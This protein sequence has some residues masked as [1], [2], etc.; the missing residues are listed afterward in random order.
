[1]DNRRPFIQITYNSGTPT[2]PAC[3]TA[4]TAPANAASICAGATTLS[5]PAVTGATG[6]DVYLNT[7][8]T[9]TTVVSANQ[10]GTTY[11][12]TVAAGTYAWK[13]VPKNAAGDA[14]GCATFNFTVNPAVTP[15][16]SIA[17]SPSGTICAGTPVTFTATATNGGAA[18][19]FQ[20]K[21]GT[22]NVGTSSTTYT[23]N[24]LIT[25][26]AI[27]VVMTGNAACASAATV[28]S[29]VITATVSPRPTASVTPSGTASVCTGST[30]TLNANTG[31]GLTYRWQRNSADIAGANTATYTA[32]ISGTYRVLVSNG[33][34]EDT[35]AVTTV[36]ILAK[37][38][39]TV[40]PSGAAAFCQGG[41]VLLSGPAP[42]TGVTYQWQINGGNIAG[43]T[44]NTYAA[45]AQGAYRLVLS[46]GSCGD[47]SS[48]VNI[49]VNPVPV[50]TA[51][52]GGPTTFC[53]GGSVTLTANTG[54]G[55]SYSWLRNTA[56][57][58]GATTNT[59][60]ANTSGVYAVIVANTTTGCSDT[61]D[62]GIPRF[63][64]ADDG[65]LFLQQIRVDA[66]LRD[67]GSA[68]LAGG[69]AAPGCC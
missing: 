16:I 40:S 32:S 63:D 11:N 27:S 23:D 18:P 59:Y 67:N 66:D 35:S 39:A 47:T 65:G 12:A 60:S 51:T 13:V 10:T 4:P 42:A 37:P 56:L 38:V 14:T 57:I 46:N 19:T 2:V 54:T 17:A 24:A 58:A 64:P 34:C 50:A 3:V 22:T 68:R 69:S 15:T 33:T 9:A 43:A 6:Y 36:N 52:A 49:T 1:M 29:N 25:G 21:K 20:W 26:N 45:S 44:S 8:A 48:V 53:T 5:W 62:P 55:L 61:L 7:G 31:T 30:V 28:T 41:S